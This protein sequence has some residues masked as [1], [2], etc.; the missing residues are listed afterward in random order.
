MKRT[1]ILLSLLA[2]CSAFTVQYAANTNAT[3]VNGNQFTYRKTEVIDLSF[4]ALFSGIYFSSIAVTANP[5]Y[6]SIDALFG[7][8]YAGFNNPPSVYLTFFKVAAMWTPPTATNAAS[9]NA[10]GSDGFIGKAYVALQEVAPNGTIVQVVRLNGLSWSVGTKNVG[11]GGL[12]YWSIVGVQPFNANPNFKVTVTHVLSDVVGVLNVG[13]TPILTPKSIETILEILNFPYVSTQ[14]Q[15]KLI[16]GVGTAAATL[17]VQGTATHFVS[18]TGTGTAYFSASNVAQIGGAVTPV[19]VTSTVTGVSAANFTND[20]LAGQVVAKYGAAAEFRIVTVL[21]PAGATDIIYDPSIG[22]GS[23]PPLP[24]NS[25][26]F[27]APSFFFALFA[28]ALLRL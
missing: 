26:S 1:L 28:L 8:A 9:A 17:S 21:F 19:S 4:P 10:T 14:N 6:G 7:S 15:V 27:A 2:L 25:G 13:G 24:G 3:L 20:A 11:Q 18:G 12:R 22:A 16:I 23:P 5:N